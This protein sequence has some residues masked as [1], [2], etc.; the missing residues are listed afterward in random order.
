MKNINLTLPI[1]PLP[2]FLLPNGVT[3]LRIF[4]PRYLKLVKIATTKQGFVILLNSESLPLPKIIWGSWV[5]IINFDQDE[6]GVL[7]IDVKCKSLVR[8]LSIFQTDEELQFS[9]ISEIKH[10]SQKIERTQFNAL[11]AS[12][13]T[14]FENNKKLS[15]LYH[16]KPTNNTHWVVARWLELL[17]IKLEIKNTF[18]YDHNF[19]EAENFVQSIIIKD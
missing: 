15:G 4:E 13:E 19:Q 9:S 14:V 18:I 1:F 2:V 11:S 7:E 6:G 17:P 3:R 5:E 8:L 16:H 12:L 10:W